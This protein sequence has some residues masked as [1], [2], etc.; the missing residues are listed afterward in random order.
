MVV[1]CLSAHES[2]IPGINR[3][4]CGGEDRKK[5]VWARVYEYG[6]ECTSMGA[7]DN[8]RRTRKNLG[9]GK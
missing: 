8:Q 2:E 6:L 4:W 3:K 7:T 9:S 5:R 1:A